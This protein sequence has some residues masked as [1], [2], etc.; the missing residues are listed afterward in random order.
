[1]FLP[2]ASLLAERGSA[3]W[4]LGLLV[5]AGLN[6]LVFHGRTY[7]TVPDW[8]LDRPAPAP[9]RTA[10]VISLTAWAGVT[11]AGSLLAYT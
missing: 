3:P 11:V 10:A 7:R 8:D 4:K 6:V 1:M 2:G 9:A 5:V